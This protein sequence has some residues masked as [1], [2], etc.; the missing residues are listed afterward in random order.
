MTTLVLV[1]HAKSDWGQPGLDDHDRPL[2]ARGERDAPVMAAR[3]AA[4]GLRP[5]LVLSSTALRA[6]TTA[7]AFA[8]ALDAELRLDADLYGAPGAR[9][10]DAAAA[11][12][13]P[14]V[15]VVAH[16]P[17][18]TVLAERLSGG[19][20]GHMPT[21]AVATFTWHTDDWDVATA[22]DPDDWTVDT[23]R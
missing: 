22:V 23:P 12:G 20:I 6:R 5:E 21:C 13:L 3:L 17:G 19:G 7:A 11:T 16:D 15:V 1:R 9:L 14:H 4:T 18:M 2:N 10:L 8:E